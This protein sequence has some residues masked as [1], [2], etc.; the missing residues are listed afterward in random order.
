[1][2]RLKKQ[3]KEMVSALEH[4]L[5]KVTLESTFQT[6]FSN[7]LMI[8]ASMVRHA[9]SPDSRERVAAASAPHA[10]STLKNEIKSVP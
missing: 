3:K 5:Y 4:L 2:Q 1:M 10:A 8:S 7:R 6:A 9:A